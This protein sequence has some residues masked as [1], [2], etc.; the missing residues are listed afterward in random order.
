MQRRTRF[1]RLR[2]VL[3]QKHLE[4]VL[5]K[6]RGERNGIG[7]ASVRSHCQGKALV[8]TLQGH[9]IFTDFCRFLPVIY[10]TISGIVLDTLG[11]PVAKG[12]AS[13]EILN[14][15]Q[16]FPIGHIFC[17]LHRE[18]GRSALAEDGIHCRYKMSES[19]NP[20][21]TVSVFY[22]TGHAESQLDQ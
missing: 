1:L 7:I 15:R 3:F 13:A 6:G 4:A 11:L 14:F 22:P 5:R 16:I 8:R 12:L 21:A 18:A 10:I 2:K 9:G 20:L 17:L 19:E